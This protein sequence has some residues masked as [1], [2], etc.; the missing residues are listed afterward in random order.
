MSETLDE[1]LARVGANAEPEKKEEK[2]EETKV[3]ET[4][5]E[6]KKE[7]PEPDKEPEKVEG[8]EELEEEEGNTFFDKL[9]AIGAEKPASEEKKEEKSTEIPAD[10]LAELESYKS[11]LA[12]YETDPLHK[13]VEMG[14][15]QDELLTIAAELKGK[16]YSKTSYQD[17]LASDIAALTGLEGEELLEQ[18]ELALEEYN[19]LPKYK[20]IAQEK[21]LR[22]KF[23]S[24]SKKGES[25][26]LQAIQAAYEEKSKGLKKP[27][28]I[29]KEIEAIAAT[30]KE[31]IKSFGSQLVGSKLYGVELT[32]EILDEIVNKDYHV[33]KVSEYLD[34]KGS[35]DIPKFIESKFVIKN[36][37]KM[38][39]LAEKRGEKKANRG[40]ARTTTVK[41]KSVTTTPVDPN[42]EELRVLGVPDHVLNASK[43][44]VMRD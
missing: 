15:S 6:P 3:E 25:P 23:Q 17:L 43:P 36:L 40:A 19:S 10:V 29:Q 13:A 24:Q 7:E 35:L 26:T 28:D 39:E 2:V 44:L 4:K 21:E 42:K 22:A 27:E 31:A 11:K 20:Q 16:D 37:A 1:L 38:I 9:K 32:Q 33:D 8:E 14:A 5:V 34:E 18:V 30:E 41:N 12:K